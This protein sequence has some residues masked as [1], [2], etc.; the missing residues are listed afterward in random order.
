MKPLTLLVSMNEYQDGINM[1][2][3]IR[4]YDDTADVLL[5]EAKRGNGWSVTAHICIPA[6][7]SQK[8]IAAIR[9]SGALCALREVGEA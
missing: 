3:L 8:L 9:D 1:A 5:H 6:S 7:E 2:N 4:E